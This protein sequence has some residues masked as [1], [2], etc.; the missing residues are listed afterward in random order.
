MGIDTPVAGAKLSAFLTRHLARMDDTALT[1]ALMQ[2]AAYPQPVSDIGLIET[3]ISRL[4]LAGDLAY[5][6]R[7]PVKFDFVDFSTA[8][9]RQED[10]ET[11]VRLNRRFAPA[12][13]LGVVP[14]APDRIGAL[15]MEGDGAPV[16]YAVKMRRFP[17]DA[18]L[19][20]M[21]GAQRLTPAHVDALA[22]RIADCH[23]QLPHASPADGYGAPARIHATLDECLGGIARLTG[24]P[25]FAAIVA[26]QARARADAVAPALCARLLGGHVRECHGDLHLG[27]IV[28]L[29]GQPTPF[30][31]LEFNPALRWTDTIHDLAFPFMDLLHRGRQDLAYRLLNGYLEH[32]GDYAGLVLLPFYVAMRAL[33]RARVGLERAHQQSAS[34]PAAQAECLGLLQL[35]SHYLTR[36]PAAMLVMHGLSGSGK[37]TVAARLCESGAM[38]RVRSDVE[39]KRLRHGMTSAH[40]WY[41]DRETER[42]YRRV[43]AICRL[44][45]RAGF[46]MIADATFLAQARREPFA[47]QA[48]RLGV[49]FHIVAC[50]APVET[51]R[52]RIVARAQARQD[53]SDADIAVLEQQLRTHDPLTPAERACVISADELPGAGH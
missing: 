4:F 38:V 27:N 41:G 31:C 13:Y 47:R 46:P 10:C 52:A 25:A 45:C 22:R 15:R 35:A 8:Q 2:P 53:P 6:V 34:M 19:S 37:S 50:E 44:G 40:G 32:G 18:L 23:A 9:A 3:H 11:E 43:L 17:Q 28:L 7:K 51:L 1:S 30:D 21:I 26:A 39:R 20:E 12:L 14:I 29:D 42:T 33:V 49:P 5:K 48:R 16:E 36:P 24:D